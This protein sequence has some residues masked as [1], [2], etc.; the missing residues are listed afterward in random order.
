MKTD[1]KLELTPNMHIEEEPPTTAAPTATEKP[2]ETLEQ[3]EDDHSEMLN[4]YTLMF[5][6]EKLQDG[7]K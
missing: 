6:D 3:K 1:P 5:K 2:Q 7:F 4:M